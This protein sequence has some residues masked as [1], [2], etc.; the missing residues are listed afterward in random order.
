MKPHEI[1]AEATAVN[2]SKRIKIPLNL[3]SK[4]VINV[5]LHISISRIWLYNETC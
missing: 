5:V 1:L 3:F 4:Y 2:T